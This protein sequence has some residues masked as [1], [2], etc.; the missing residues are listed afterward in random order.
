MH[1]G[2]EDTTAACGGSSFIAKQELI[3]L[4][5]DYQRADAAQGFAGFAH[6]N[7]TA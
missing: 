6:T 5:G 2:R 4:P 3:P 7:R 1:S